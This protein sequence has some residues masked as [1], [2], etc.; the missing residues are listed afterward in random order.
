M[1]VC[2]VGN[3]PSAEGHGPEIDASDFIVRMKAFWLFG[4]VDSGERC[5]AWA[6]FGETDPRRAEAVPEAD[7][8]NVGARE[9]WFTQCNL[10]IP[11]TKRY[12]LELAQRFSDVARWRQISDTLWK[13]MRAHLG[14][15]PST[16]ITAVAMAIDLLPVDELLLFGFDGTTPDK[17]NY[18]DARRPNPNDPHAHDQLAEKR[19][20]AELLDGQWLGEPSKVKLI[21]PDMPELID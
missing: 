16:G 7:I 8:D 11:E 12:R 1:K 4:A 14:R 20:I 15:F 18:H 10:Q 5:D 6:W 3:G 19:A 9:H 17:P 2:I 13:R 21:W